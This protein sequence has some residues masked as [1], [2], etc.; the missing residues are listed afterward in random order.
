MFINK[1][2]KILKILLLLVFLVIFVS[3]VL[4]VWFG[5]GKRTITNTISITI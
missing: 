2:S 1:E 4:F 3:V 5:N